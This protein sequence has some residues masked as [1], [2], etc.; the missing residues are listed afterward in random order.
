MTRG[1]VLTTMLAFVLFGGPLVAQ[2]QAPVSSPAQA[3]PEASARGIYLAGTA[4]GVSA[5]IEIE[6][7][8]KR[9]MVP[10]TFQF[11]S[12]D[13]FW[14]HV[15]SNRTAY[16]YVLNRTVVGDP[17]TAASRGIK[18]MQQEDAKRPDPNAYTLVFPAPDTAAPQVKAGVTT[19]LPGGT[20]FFAMD[21]VPGAE[22]LIVVATESPSTIAQFFDK[23]TGKLL[24]HAGSSVDSS[25]SVLNRL[26][27]SLATLADNTR[28]EEVPRSRGI[29]IVSLPGQP[30]SAQRQPT[31]PAKPATPTGRTSTLA[32]HAA[33]KGNGGLMQE[34]TLIHLAP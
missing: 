19:R 17:Q 10:P 7:D 33:S 27:E 5:E 15:T 13:K 34:L 4:L 9:G 16:I 3:R 25:S 22:K 24:A 26:N 12:G 18:L 6:R 30:S 2:S 1:R 23:S 29:A 32:S 31:A 14:L 11:R 28:S 8:G 21:N 20:Q